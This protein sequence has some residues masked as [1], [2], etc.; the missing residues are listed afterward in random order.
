MSK[1]IHACDQNVCTVV[2]ANQCIYTSRTAVTYATTVNKI[3]LPVK[4]VLQVINTQYDKNWT[5][6]THFVYPIKGFIHFPIVATKDECIPI[7]V[8]LC[9]LHLVNIQY[10]FDQFT[11]NKLFID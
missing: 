2:F 3:A 1:T 6:G 10:V 8:P 4:Q 7:D 9:Y 5:I 11:G